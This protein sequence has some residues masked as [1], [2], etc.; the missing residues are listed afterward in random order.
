MIFVLPR[1]ARRRQILLESMVF[2]DLF[3]GIIGSKK[4]GGFLNARLTKC[5]RQENLTSRL[6]WHGQMNPGLGVGTV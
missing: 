6:R 3:I 1:R 4:E 5:W 2:T